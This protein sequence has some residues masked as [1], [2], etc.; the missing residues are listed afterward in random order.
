MQ[1]GELVLQN[2]DSDDRKLGKCENSSGC[3]V[4][5]VTLPLS[6][7]SIFVPFFFVVVFL[8]KSYFIM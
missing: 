7:I 4:D 6:F 8:L 1:F 5:M 2:I 3:V